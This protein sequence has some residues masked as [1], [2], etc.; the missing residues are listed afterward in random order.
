[1]EELITLADEHNVDSI[2]TTIEIAIY[3]QMAV[4]AYEAGNWKIAILLLNKIVSR[5]CNPTDLNQK[6]AS[7][8]LPIFSPCLGD[9]LMMLSEASAHE[10]KAEDAMKSARCAVDIVQSSIERER[11]SSSLPEGDAPQSSLE[12]SW[13]VG[14]GL[15]TPYS[16]VCCYFNLGSLLDKVGLIKFGVG[17][18]KRALTVASDSKLESSLVSQLKEA[19]SMAE[20]FM[21]LDSRSDVLV[22]HSQRQSAATPPIDANKD[23]DDN[24]DEQVPEQDE[25]VSQTQHTD[26]KAVRTT[27]NT[28]DITEQDKDMDLVLCGNNTNTYPR[29]VS[30]A[31]AVDDFA[32]SHFRG[33]SLKDVGKSKSARARMGSSELSLKV[34]PAADLDGRIIPNPFPANSNPTI[35][36]GA[37]THMPKSPV[38]KAQAQLPGVS[39]YANSINSVSYGSYNMPVSALTSCKATPKKQ[40]SSSQEGLGFDEDDDAGIKN[41]DDDISFTDEIR[42]NNAPMSMY[43]PPVSR[44]VVQIPQQQPK[45]QPKQQQQQQL[46]RTEERLFSDD[47]DVDGEAEADVLIDDE[48]VEDKPQDNSVYATVSSG[49]KATSELQSIKKSDRKQ[50]RRNRNR[51]KE[52]DRDGNGEENDERERNSNDRGSSTESVSTLNT[53]RSEESKQ[54]RERKQKC[55][56]TAEYKAA[57]KVMHYAA[58]LINSVG[59]GYVTRKYLKAVLRHSAFMSKLRKQRRAAIVIQAAVRSYI[60]RAKVHSLLLLRSSLTSITLG[61]SMKSSLNVTVGDTPVFQPYSGVSTATSV[62][63]GDTVLDPFSP[64]RESTLTEIESAK[65]NFISSRSNSCNNFGN[66]QGVQLPVIT[67]GDMSSMIQYIQAERRGIAHKQT[68]LIRLTE[69]EKKKL[70]SM[71]AE[72]TLRDDFLDRQVP[73]PLSRKPSMMSRSPSKRNNWG[74]PPSSPKCNGSGVLQQSPN[75]EFKTRGFGRDPTVNVCTGTGLST[76]PIDASNAKKTGTAPV[77][78]LP[79]TAQFRK[80]QKVEAKYLGSVIKNHNITW[81]GGRILHVHDRKH[82]VGEKVRFHYDVIFSNGEIEL[83]VAEQYIRLPLT[84]FSA[85]QNAKAAAAVMNTKST[86]AGIGAGAGGEGGAGGGA[87]VGSTPTGIVPPTSSRMLVARRNMQETSMHKFAMHSQF[88]S[89]GRK[90]KRQEERLAC[91]NHNI[92]IFQKVFRGFIVRKYFYRYKRYIMKEK[93]IATVN[94]GSMSKSKNTNRSKQKLKKVMTGVLLMSYAEF[95]AKYYHRMKRDES[96]VLS[97]V[98]AGLTVAHNSMDEQLHAENKLLNSEIQAYYAMLISCQCELQNLR[99]S[100][101]TKSRAATDKI[102]RL[103]STVKES[104]RR[105]EEEAQPQLQQFQQQQLQQQQ[106]QRQHSSPLFAGLPGSGS[107]ADGVLDISAG[108]MEVSVDMT[109]TNNDFSRMMYQTGIN[110]S[111]SSASVSFLLDHRPETLGG[112]RA[113]TD[114]LLDPDVSSSAAIDNNSDDPADYQST[115][116]LD[117]RVVHSIVQEYV[118]STI[119][120]ALTPK[121]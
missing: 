108:D 47:E 119:Q 19:Y 55:H 65:S 30:V 118:Q 45:Q 98:K 61:N 82:F 52:W 73:P 14:P 72:L 63:F 31:A 13:D 113:S 84:C 102:S 12:D 20:S 38:G 67:N 105:Q 24:E 18:Y 88:Q 54:R 117:M 43:M 29:H 56:S 91:R 116:F 60:A 57:Y 74:S 103:H 11:S 8:V 5:C 106:S 37:M 40:D 10:N 28:S 1:M 64:T 25:M 85:V 17:W 92:T 7:T 77:T 48:N 120:K 16:L 49:T 3:R 44:Q 109:S 112:H 32:S 86:S 62:H 2:T 94:S 22:T 46:Q 59:R 70:T 34:R 110:P 39:A 121:K 75:T 76:E 99:N 27:S 26:S 50:R 95:R 4:K 71:L 23:N 80:G 78:S 35:E 58:T 87:A 21:K 6:S 42:V 33:P 68:E 107:P 69:L 104:V 90:A 100:I 96:E 36:P 97:P 53:G 115:N 79:P 9:A 114:I 101:Y 41:D 83:K 66:K 81:H 51:N 93:L 15:R 89:I 111:G